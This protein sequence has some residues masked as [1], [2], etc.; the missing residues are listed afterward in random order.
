M[1]NYVTY[2]PSDA[3]GKVILSDGT[4]HQFDKPLTVAELMLEHSQ[5]V[6][7]E[8]HS[9]VNEK[10]PSPLP[11]DKIL[12]TKKIYI[13]L[14]V[15]RGRRPAAL[16]S[17]EVRRILLT[18]NSVLWRSRPSVF[19]SPR[20]LPNLFARICHTGLGDGQGVHVMHKK[21]ISGLEQRTEKISFVPEF[22]PEILDGRPEYMSRQLSGKGWKPGL[23]TI[24]EKKV[25]KKLLHWVF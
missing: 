18:A 3:T 12:E 14:P 6:V 13:M 1:G 16:S 2:R 7:V 20:F 8:L 17:E 24:K 25:K 11:A 10:R 9:A 19:S 23:N 22:L 5:H 21:E 4:V 15:K